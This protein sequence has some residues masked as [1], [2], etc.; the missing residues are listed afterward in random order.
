[1]RGTY[2]WLLVPTQPKP[3]GPI[4]FQE[5][6]ISGDD[7]FYERAARRLR[8]DAL[9]IESWSPD[10]LRM[11]LDRYMWGDEKGWEVGLKQLWEYLAQYVYLPRLRD[12]DVLLDAVQDG[13]GRLDPPIAYATGKDDQGYHTGV[14]FQDMSGSIYFDDRSLLIH[15]E[16]V[17]RK[18]APQPAH[19]ENGGEGGE[20]G[21]R[22][23]LPTP[24]GGPEP[25]PEPEPETKPVRYYGRVAVDPQ[26]VNREIS[27]V[28]EE[29]IQR[30]TSQ[31]GTEVEIALEIK[32]KQPDGFDDQTV[33]TI[34]ENSRTLKFEDFGFEEG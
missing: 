18:P 10:N 26:R 34:S 7:N 24:G 6:R 33:R 23:T 30:L 13:V 17:N 15:P 9:L 27:L 20:E 3:L 32:A 2:S 5:S 21:E 14:L 11:E 19:V 29:V 22:V 12:H 25:E 8:N 16:H 1:M 4:E 31:M 28:V